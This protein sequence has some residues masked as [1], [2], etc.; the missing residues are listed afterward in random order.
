MKD[1]P[2]NPKDISSQSDRNN[3]PTGLQDLK[4]RIVNCGKAIGLSVDDC[5]GGWA[6]MVQFAV[7]RHKQNREELEL[8]KSKEK[9]ARELNS[10]ACSINYD[11]GNVDQLR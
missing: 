8:A 11:R 7:E 9:G 3:S 6:D 2:P 5:P 4:R 10:L 1:D